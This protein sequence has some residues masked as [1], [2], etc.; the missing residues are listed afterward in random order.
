VTV[1]GRV[2]DEE[3]AAAQL[4]DTNPAQVHMTD[5]ALAVG[6]AP[7]SAITGYWPGPSV[8]N[9]H[10]AAAAQ[11][12]RTRTPEQIAAGMNARGESQVNRDTLRA[13]WCQGDRSPAWRSDSS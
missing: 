8:A 7:A 4:L 2:S 9:W 1:E 5:R 13:P 10:A 3:A 6:Q 11:Q 12:S